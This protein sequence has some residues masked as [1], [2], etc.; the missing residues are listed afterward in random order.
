MWPVGVAAG[1][2][3]V[4]GFIFSARGGELLSN[5]PEDQEITV[6]SLHLIQVSLALVNT[7]MLQDVLAEENCKAS[8]KREDWH[9]LTPLFYQHVNPNWRFMLD[10]TQCIPLSLTKMDENLASSAAR[11]QGCLLCSALCESTLAPE[12]GFWEGKMS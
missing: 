5:R 1:R 2:N 3:S 6:L 8:M 10:L 4:N 7:L 9:G 11:Q 12:R